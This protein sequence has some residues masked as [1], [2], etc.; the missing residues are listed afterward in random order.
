MEYIYNLP[1]IRDID[2]EAL[3]IR[4]NEMDFEGQTLS[5]TIYRYIIGFSLFVSLIVSFYTKVMS[6][7]VYI[8]IL[9]T[10]IATIASVPSWPCYN[11]NPINWLP[12]VKQKSNE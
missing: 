3:G 8:I 5:E 10:L 7:G 6:N 11:K 9:G 1:I 4:M 2:L 12:C